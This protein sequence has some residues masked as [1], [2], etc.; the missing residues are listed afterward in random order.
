M[1]SLSGTVVRGVAHGK[2]EFVLHRRLLDEGLLILHN[3]HFRELLFT[4]SASN[5]LSPVDCHVHG[6]NILGKQGGGNDHPTL[7]SALDITW[8]V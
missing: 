1:D 6:A 8:D 7:L 3:E 4:Q 2:T 5:T